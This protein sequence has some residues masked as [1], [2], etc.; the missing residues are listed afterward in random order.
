VTKL[1]QSKHQTSHSKGQRKVTRQLHLH[2]GRAEELT[3]GKNQRKTDT[4]PHRK[5]VTT[6][7]AI[8]EKLMK[9]KTMNIIERTGINAVCMCSS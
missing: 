6:V 4:K 3:L 2:R 8:T 1:I 5:S 7:T 9:K